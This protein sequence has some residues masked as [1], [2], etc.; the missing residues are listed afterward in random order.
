VTLEAQAQGYG[1]NTIVWL[2]QGIPTSAPLCDV[3]Y[4]VTVSNVVVSGKPQLF[5]YGVTIIDPDVPAL[6]VRLGATNSLVLSW[7]SS[8]TGYLLQ[9]NSS[10]TNSSGWTTVSVT[11]QI[12]GNQYVATVPLASGQR[13]YRL[14]K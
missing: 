12:V 1:D 5:T 11:P 14:R 2:P 4:T 13:L 10:P 9:Q 7:P 6:S 3:N 8:S